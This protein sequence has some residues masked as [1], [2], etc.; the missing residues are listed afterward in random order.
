ML[1]LLAQIKKKARQN[2]NEIQRKNAGVKGTEIKNMLDMQINLNDKG[3]KFRR[4]K[5]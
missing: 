3:E 4:R 2:Q 5:S 1:T